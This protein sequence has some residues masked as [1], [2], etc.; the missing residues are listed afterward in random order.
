MICRRRVLLGYFGE[1][2]EKD[3]GHCDVCEHPPET[4][5]GSLAAQ[6]FLSAV[7]RT[8]GRATLRHCALILRGSHAQDI[9]ESGWTDLK[10]FGV[11]KELSYE[12]WMEYG[13]QLINS[14]YASVAYDRGMSLQL[15]PLASSVLKG[16]KSVALVKFMSFE[17]K[18][19]ASAAPVKAPAASDGDP[20]LFERLKAARKKLAD[21]HQVP[22][23][24]IFSDKTLK[25]MASKLPMSERD[26]RQVHGV[27][28]VKA[29]AYGSI[30]LREIREWTETSQQP[31]A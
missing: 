10:T 6:K 1:S 30:F 2:L 28:E 8:G 23:Y 26:F 4:F 17:E 7:Y 14:G 11:G 20:E 3:C 21:E 19:A 13:A 9:E 16:E 29:E 25:D 5:D 18:K 15:S 24:V 12:E 27:G 31:P 22:A